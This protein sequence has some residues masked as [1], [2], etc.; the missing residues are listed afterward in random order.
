V[1][2]STENEKPVYGGKS[3]FIDQ[4]HQDHVNTSKLLVSLQK[5]MEAFDKGEATDFGLM[6][7]IIDYISEY[8]DKVHHPKEDLIYTA[9]ENRDPGCKDL[10]DEL[11]KEHKQLSS[12]TNDF[13]LTLEEIVL[14]SVISRESVSKQGHDFILQNRKHLE[15]EE[16]TIFPLVIKTLTN[17]DWDSIEPSLQAQDDPLFGQSIQE[18]YKTLYSQI[19]NQES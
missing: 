17:E 12:L 11:H 6:Q 5:Q 8:T 18:K 9:L 13:T 16:K 4:L 3:M 19:T 2:D 10:V 15:K 14:D 1:Q 7:N